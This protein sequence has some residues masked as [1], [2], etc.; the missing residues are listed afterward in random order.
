MRNYHCFEE[1]EDGSEA[2]GCEASSGYDARW[3]EVEGWLLA[4]G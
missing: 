1:G 2:E 4:G 3:G